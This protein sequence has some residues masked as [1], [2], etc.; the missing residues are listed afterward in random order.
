MRSST[1]AQH[2]EQHQ[3]RPHL[4]LDEVR[5][6]LNEEVAHPP[7]MPADTLWRTTQKGGVYSNVNV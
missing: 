5:A 4:D 1:E 3:R 7:P 6:R 2:D